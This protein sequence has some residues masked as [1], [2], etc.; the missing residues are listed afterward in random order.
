MPP[1]AKSWA[2]QW[3]RPCTRS[4]SSRHWKRRRATSGFQA[5][6]SCILTGQPVQQ[7]KF[8]GATPKT[9]LPAKHG[10]K[11]RGAGQGHGRVLFP[12]F[13]AELPG[14]S[15]FDDYEQAFSRTFEF[16]EVYHNRTPCGAKPFSFHQQIAVRKNRVILGHQPQAGGPAAVHPST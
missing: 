8:Q 11:G 5:G 16:I 14:K 7:R 6:W 4:W 2:G 1:A 15:I 10:A 3:P 12:R 9:R 13:K